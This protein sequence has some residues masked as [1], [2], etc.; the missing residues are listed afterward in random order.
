MRAKLLLSNAFRP[1]IQQNERKNVILVATAESGP[2][3][4]PFVFI[5]DLS[6]LDSLAA[7]ADNR[8]IVVVIGGGSAPSS[9][10]G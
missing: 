8:E 7:L 2:C 10:L 5:Q 9:F 4:F 6:N 1:S 3:L